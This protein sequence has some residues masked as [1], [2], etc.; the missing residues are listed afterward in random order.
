MKRRSLRDLEPTVP[1]PQV[2]ARYRELVTANQ[3]L[4]VSIG[5]LYVVGEVFYTVD[6]R[7][8]VLLPAVLPYLWCCSALGRL[9]RCFGQEAWTTTTSAFFF[10]PWELLL[11]YFAYGRGV[12]AALAAGDDEDLP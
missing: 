4:F 6:V 7:A 8:F 9:A 11:A 2:R 10:Y 12:R 1:L 5:V 3:A